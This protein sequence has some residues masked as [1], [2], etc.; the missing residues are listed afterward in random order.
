[1]GPRNL[2]FSASAEHDPTR[3]RQLRLVWLGAG[4]L[5][6]YYGLPAIGLMWVVL[7]NL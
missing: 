3:R 4:F 6:L 1:M 2:K 7:R 5:A